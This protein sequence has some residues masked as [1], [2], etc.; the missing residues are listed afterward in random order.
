MDRVVHVEVPVD[1]VAGPGR[2]APAPPI[3]P[4]PASNAGIAGAGAVAGVGLLLQQKDGVR[5][6]TRTAERTL[7]ALGGG[8]WAASAAARAP[9]QQ[10]LTPKGPHTSSVSHQQCL[11]PPTSPRQAGSLRA[12]AWPGAADLGVA[13][14][15]RAQDFKIYVERVVQG[16][17]ADRSLSRLLFSLTEA[18]RGNSGP[19][20]PRRDPPP[21]PARLS[22]GR[23]GK[24]EKGDVL[25][26]V[27]GRSVHDLDLDAVRRLITGPEGSPVALQLLRA[28]RQPYT[29]TMARAHPPRP[30]GAPE[31]APGGGG[32]ARKR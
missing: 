25:V 20:A 24:I 22:R 7:D 11:T 32:S 13:G 10:R 12:R 1:R 17:A 23:S 4:G 3:R 5:L 9:H 6:H 19:P 8:A 28:G 27:D 18:A 14:P 31:A 2:A 21:A 29:A 30:G 16:C 15:F 26:S